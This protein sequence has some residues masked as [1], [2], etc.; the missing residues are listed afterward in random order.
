MKNLF[1]SSPSPMSLFPRETVSRR[2]LF[3]ILEMMAVESPEK[4]GTLRSASG[5]KERAPSSISTGILSALLSSTF[6]L[7]TLYVPPSTC[8]QGSMERRYRGVMDIIRGA[9]FVV[10]ARLRATEVVTLRC[11]RLRWFCWL[12]RWR[13][14]V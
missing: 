2:N 11:R 4:S 1:Q 9:V 8:T 7:L 5:A 3:A 12:L 14:W 13:L 6:V 10:L